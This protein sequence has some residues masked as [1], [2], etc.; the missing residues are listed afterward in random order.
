LKRDGYVVIT[1][2]D[3][4]LKTIFIKQLGLQGECLWSPLCRPRLW[5]M[6]T[7]VD[8]TGYIVHL[9]GNRHALFDIFKTGGTWRIQ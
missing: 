8:Q 1:T 9:L 5:S 4:Y 2:R 7:R 6:T 3:L